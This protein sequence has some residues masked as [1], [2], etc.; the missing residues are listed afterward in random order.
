MQALIS[1]NAAFVAA[2]GFNLP[3]NDAYRDYAGQVAARNYW[4]GQGNCGFAAVPGTSN[5]GWALAID[6]GVPRTGWSDPTYVWLKANGPSYGWTH[7]GWAEP[8]G[9]YP[10]AWHWEYTGGGSSAPSN[11]QP[12]PQQSIGLDDMAF[13][14]VTPINGVDA[15]GGFYRWLIDPSSGTTRNIDGAEYDF[16]KAVGYKELAGLQSPAVSARYQQIHPTPTTP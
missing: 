14:C 10:E 2:R 1:L 13:L 15:T 3:I 12:E 11:P 16:L 6:V 5:H 9:A 4:C 7:P 8:G